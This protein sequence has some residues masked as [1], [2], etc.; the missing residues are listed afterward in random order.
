[1]TENEAFADQWRAIAPY[2]YLLK[3]LI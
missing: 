2:L 1:M 3:K